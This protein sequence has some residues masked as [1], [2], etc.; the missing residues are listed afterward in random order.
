M[1]E[2]VFYG[3]ENLNFYNNKKNKPNKIYKK[4]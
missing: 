2:I 4:Q 1:K 3:K